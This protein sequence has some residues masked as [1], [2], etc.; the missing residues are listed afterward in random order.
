MLTNKIVQID[1]RFFIISLKDVLG[2][3][4]ENLYVLHFQP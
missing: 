2:K 3:T 1:I 4:L